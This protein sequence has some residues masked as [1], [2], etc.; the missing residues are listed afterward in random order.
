MYKEKLIS[1]FPF[2]DVESVPLTGKSRPIASINS[3]DPFTSSV[4]RNGKL[5]G[6]VKSE[7]VN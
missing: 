7:R 5:L 3:K 6:K 4:V 2:F 1:M